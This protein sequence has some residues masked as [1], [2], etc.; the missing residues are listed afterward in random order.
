[1]SLKP[2]RIPV[3][4]GSSLA[5]SG[6]VDGAVALGAAAAQRSKKAVPPNPPKQGKAK[7]A[8][9]KSAHPTPFQTSPSSMTRVKADLNCGVQYNS[10]GGPIRHT[11]VLM[12]GSCVVGSLAT[13]SSSALVLANAGGVNTT[14]LKLSVDPVGGGT[15]AS[16]FFMLPDVIRNACL[17]FVRH[18]WHKF[19]LTYI[20]VCP[21]TTSG[22]IVMA[23]SPEVVAYS[24]LTNYGTSL[25]TFSR[26]CSTPVW[27]AIS[28][29]A[30]GH[31]GI[32]G[33]WYYTDPTSTLSETS[34]RQECAGS[35]FFGALGNLPAS[36][37]LGYIRLEFTLEVE[38]LQSTALFNS[39]QPES[40]S[41]VQSSGSVIEPP[42]VVAPQLGQTGPP[43]TPEHTYVYVPGNQRYTPHL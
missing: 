12:T 29:N 19:R 23:A 35:L 34:L 3:L 17:S 15:T 40:E 30:F 18:R 31:D 42:P 37:P 5:L 41:K 14:T 36:I 16:N 11:P 20:P 43:P 9:G 10:T 28:M 33:G 27:S 26:N 4:R 25:V 6:L 39:E 2:S 1:M 22:Q 32:D 13:N 38:A 7:A 8:K 24:D 21:T